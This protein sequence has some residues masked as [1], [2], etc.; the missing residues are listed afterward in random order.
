MSGTRAAALARAGQR[1][2]VLVIGVML[3]FAVAGFIEAWV[4][5]S[6]LP[7]WTRV[8]IGVVVEAIF[9]VYAFGLG[10]RAARSEMTG[11]FGE[12][13]TAIPTGDR[14]T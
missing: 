13:P 2:V 8:G 7:T 6:N 5:P 14:S 12:V 9:L 3:T 4:T 1:A 11:L 10:A